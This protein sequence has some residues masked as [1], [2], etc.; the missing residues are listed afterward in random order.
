MDVWTN[1]QEYKLQP[2]AGLIRADAHRPPFRPELQV[3]ACLAFVHPGPQEM[4]PPA[5]LQLSPWPSTCILAFHLYFAAPHCCLHVS[6]CALIT[7]RKQYWLNIADVGSASSATLTVVMYGHQGVMCGCVQ[8]CSPCQTPPTCQMSAAVSSL[9]NSTTFML[10]LGCCQY[11][12]HCCQSVLH[13]QLFTQCAVLCS[14][15]QQLIRGVSL[16][17]CC[18]AFLMPSFVIPLMGSELVAGRALPRIMLSKTVNFTSPPPTHTALRSA[19]KTCCIWLPS[20]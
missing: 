5:W 9:S 2:P 17:V 3:N 4:L 11:M 19:C 8:T 7:L 6:A 1:F 18:R 12:L 15:V 10:S 14:V 13:F 16:E 20:T